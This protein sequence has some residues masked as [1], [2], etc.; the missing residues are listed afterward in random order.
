VIFIL[1]TSIACGEFLILLI[2]NFLGKGTKD[3]VSTLLPLM[4]FEYFRRNSV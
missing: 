2:L 4:G 1:D 3:G